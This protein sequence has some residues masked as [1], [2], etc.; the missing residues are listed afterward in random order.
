MRAGESKLLVVSRVRPLA[1]DEKKTN[2]SE[3]AC[4][5]G[6]NVSGLRQFDSSDV[7]GLSVRM[8]GRG[9]RGG[10]GLCVCRCSL[11]SCFARPTFFFSSLPPHFLIAK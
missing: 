3:V 4:V 2:A 5:V 1:V 7:L 9:E 10:G 6:Q 8:E 11:F